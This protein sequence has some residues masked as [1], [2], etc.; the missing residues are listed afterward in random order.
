MLLGN[1]TKSKLFGCNL[2]S[3]KVFV[4]VVTAHLFKAIL[5]YQSIYFLSCLKIAINKYVL[6]FNF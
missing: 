1:W 2:M 5:V 3:V 4:E 6:S